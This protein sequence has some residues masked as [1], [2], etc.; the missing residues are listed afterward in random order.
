LLRSSS[1]VQ[2]IEYAP[3][4]IRYRTFDADASEVLRLTFKPARVLADGGAL[5]EVESLRDEPAWSFDAALNVARVRHNARTV[6]IQ[7]TN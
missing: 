2:Q 1:V 5:R 6:E 3:L 4:R 7:G